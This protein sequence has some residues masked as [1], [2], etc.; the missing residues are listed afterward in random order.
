MKKRSEMPMIMQPVITSAIGKGV[1]SPNKPTSEP[2]KA[3]VANPLEPNNVEA[4][5][6][7]LG[8]DSILLELAFDTIK[9]CEP[10]NSITNSTTM[11]NG[12]KAVNPAK[13]NSSE[14]KDSC[15]DF[16]VWESLDSYYVQGT[17]HP[18]LFKL[19]V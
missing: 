3:P 5:P 19:N 15:E 8:T 12:A 10:T 2:L 6:L 18:F 11:A 9:L 1:P 13:R 17:V 4:A 7:L 14:R 16:I